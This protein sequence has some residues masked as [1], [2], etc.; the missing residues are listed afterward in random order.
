MQ[1][2]GHT[3]RHELKYYINASVYHTLRNRLRVVLK[4]D[5]NMKREDGYLISSLYFDDLHHSA[6]NEKQ[7]GIRFRKKYRM[8]CYDRSD[9]LIKLECKYKYDEYISKTSATLSRAEYDAILRNDYGFLASRREEV[10]RQ[11][12]AYHNLRLLRPVVAVEYLREAYVLPQGNVRITFDR[13][14]SSS[15]EVQRFFEKDTLRYP[16][17]AAGQQL[18]EVKFD[19][20]LP[21][22][23][24]EN[25]ETGKLQQ[26]SF[27]KYYLCRRY[28]V[29]CAGG[30]KR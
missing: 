10:C 19:E 6:L 18:M 16:V 17:L 5:P 23:I 4:P 12:L 22:F 14:L 11:L 8:R 15:M 25:L 1:Y 20:Y 21:A 27:S 28:S 13:N 24:K 2:Q 7:S 30:R 26:T 3:L 9:A 29:P